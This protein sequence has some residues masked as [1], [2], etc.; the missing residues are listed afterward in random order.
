MDYDIFYRILKFDIIGF[1]EYSILLLPR[2]YNII[3]I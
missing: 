3:I 1:Q 2:T